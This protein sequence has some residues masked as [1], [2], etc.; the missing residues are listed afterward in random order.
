MLEY[1]GAARDAAEPSQATPLAMHAVM[2]ALYYF[3]QNAIYSGGCRSTRRSRPEAPVSVRFPLH[4]PALPAARGDPP[5]EAR[6]L[7]EVKT[8][9]VRCPRE[10]SLPAAGASRPARSRPPAEAVTRA[11]GEYRSAAA[12]AHRER[13]RKAAEGAE[14]APPEGPAAGLVGYVGD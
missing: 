6:R 4:P 13:V 12:A 14:L 5:R 9:A 11:V 2:V 7:R 8:R 3:A 10:A 1:L